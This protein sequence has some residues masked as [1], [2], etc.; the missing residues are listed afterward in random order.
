MLKK[1]QKSYYLQ[2]LEQK[3]H[4]LLNYFKSLSVAGRESNP[5][6]G[7][8]VPTNQAVVWLLPFA[9]HSFGQSLSF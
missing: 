8:L 4:L 1:M 5:A 9:H 7:R 2:M 6:H 3:Q